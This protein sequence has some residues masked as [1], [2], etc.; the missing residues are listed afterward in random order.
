MKE[1]GKPFLSAQ[2]GSFSRLPAGRG[3]IA[4]ADLWL[5]LC[6]GHSAPRPPLPWGLQDQRTQPS[7]PRGLSH[8]GKGM[9]VI[10]S[11]L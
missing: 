1:G 10:H 8:S 5:H 2:P 6:W 3:R 4:A 9:E 11:E 7:A